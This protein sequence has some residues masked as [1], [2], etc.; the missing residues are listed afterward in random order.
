[1][2]AAFMNNE[3]ICQMKLGDQLCEKNFVG[4][5]PQNINVAVELRNLNH[6]EDVA[7]LANSSS[8]SNLDSLNLSVETGEAQQERNPD[9]DDVDMSLMN[10]KM[11]E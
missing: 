4:V 10:T 2:K 8:G 5:A 9:L 6:L 1:M 3:E 7:S 11:E